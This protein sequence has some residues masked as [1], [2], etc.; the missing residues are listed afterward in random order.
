MPTMK[1]LRIGPI[2]Y[3]VTYKKNIKGPRKD[4][5]YLGLTNI[6]EKFIQISSDEKEQARVSTELHE[7]LHAMIYEYE[8]RDTLADPDSEETLVKHM[9]IALVAFF[10]DNPQ[11]TKRLIKVL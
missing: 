9:T 5:Y 11:F 1:S 7:A 2:D 3:K 6:R 8:L 4:G 10:K